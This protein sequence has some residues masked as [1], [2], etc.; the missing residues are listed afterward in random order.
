MLDLLRNVNARVW[1]N[2]TAVDE[3]GFDY[4]FFSWSDTHIYNAEAQW[5]AVAGQ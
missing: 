2:V 1:V 3:E 5:V 4:D